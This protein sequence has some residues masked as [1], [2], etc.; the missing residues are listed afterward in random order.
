MSA[1]K[2]DPRKLEGETST[3]TLRLSEAVALVDEVQVPADYRTAC[4]EM[5]APV[6]E[7]LAPL[8]QSL[9]DKVTKQN[10][11]LRLADIKN[12]IKGGETVPGR[13]SITG[14]VW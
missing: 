7:G 2:K 8:N 9:I 3:L 10:L 11:K 1:R 12:V 5:P 13:T 6:W 4:I 14:I